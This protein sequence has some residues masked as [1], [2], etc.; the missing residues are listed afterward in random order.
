MTKQD[1]LDSIRTYR[2]VFNSVENNANLSEHEIMDKYFGFEETRSSADNH[3]VYECMRIHKKD[4]F[5]ELPS[6][7]DHVF[8]LNK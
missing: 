2:E 8:I 7:L 3:I 4:L 1:I 5:K 6:V